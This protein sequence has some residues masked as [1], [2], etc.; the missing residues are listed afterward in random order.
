M[1]EERP[2]GGGALTTVDT[3]S[4]EDCAEETFVRVKVTVFCADEAALPFSSYRNRVDLGLWMMGCL[5]HEAKENTLP[6]SGLPESGFG[7]S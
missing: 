7:H 5:Q 1:S 4:P 2:A 6:E 3:L